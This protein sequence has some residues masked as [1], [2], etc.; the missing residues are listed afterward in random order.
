M[1]SNSDGFTPLMRACEYDELA[2]AEVLLDMGAKINAV[3]HK[4]HTALH[5]A[6]IHSPRI[7]K[8]LLERLRLA[9]PVRLALALRYLCKAR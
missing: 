7:T 4:G 8:L 6:F 2:C 5:W 3:D 1:G 9:P